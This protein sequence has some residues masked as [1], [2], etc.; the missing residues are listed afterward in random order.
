MHI[1]R[2]DYMRRVWLCR[3]AQQSGSVLVRHMFFGRQQPFTIYLIN[4]I[5]QRSIVRM[6]VLLVGWCVPGVQAWTG[7]F[8]KFPVRDKFKF[9]LFICDI[10]R[11]CLECF[12]LENVE[13]LKRAGHALELEL[14]QINKSCREIIR[15]ARTYRLHSR[16]PVQDFTYHTCR[17]PFD[18]QIN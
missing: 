16:I 17:I 15:R 5:K 11:K 1:D 6:L 13:V 4:I 9:N 3:A 18:S 2:I 10:D 12:A 14:D 8:I 7:G